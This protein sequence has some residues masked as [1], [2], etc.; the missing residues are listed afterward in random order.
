MHGGGQEKIGEGFPGP[1]TPSLLAA[2]DVLPLSARYR[3]WHL[4]E[5]KNPALNPASQSGHPRH[6]ETQLILT[7]VRRRKAQTGKQ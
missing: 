7:D 2:T 5:N 6:T 1:G 4:E 3:T